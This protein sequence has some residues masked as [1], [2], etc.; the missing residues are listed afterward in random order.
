MSCIPTNCDSR[1]K[2]AGSGQNSDC[3][4]A[5]ST[6]SA[7][8]AFLY[9]VATSTDPISV[10]QESIQTPIPPKDTSEESHTIYYILAGIAL[11]L[12]LILYFYMKKP[13]GAA[14]NPSLMKVLTTT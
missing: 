2:V 14:L 11:L 5:A 8:A 10:C 7:C 13:A 3:Q 1:K 4:A 6:N 12:A 9:C